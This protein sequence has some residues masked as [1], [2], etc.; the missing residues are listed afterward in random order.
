[1]DAQLRGQ[2]RKNGLLLKDCQIVLEAKKTRKGL[3]EKEVGDELLV[4]IARYRAHPDCKAIVCFV[5][6]PERRIDNPTGLETDLSRER[7]NL[8]VIAIV[9]PK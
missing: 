2:V 3:G 5:Y 4:D 6:D 7:D 9:N 8:K 1:M